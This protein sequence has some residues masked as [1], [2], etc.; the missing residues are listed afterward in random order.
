M[1]SIFSTKIMSGCSTFNK[2]VI[3][4]FGG[5][6]LS[7]E[8][9]AGEVT[10]AAAGVAND[11]S[12][13]RAT[14]AAGFGWFG[15]SGIVMNWAIFSKNSSDKIKSK[16]ETFKLA[17]KRKQKKIILKMKTEISNQVRTKGFA[18]FDVSDQIDHR[19]S[20]CVGQFIDARR[21]WQ[22]LVV[23]WIFLFHESKNEKF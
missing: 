15:S 6:S 19:S 2:I 23:F 13:R 3:L 9:G 22:I 12:T 14:G 4:L 8:T 7:D 10:P 17:V 16:L 20:W 5:V 11:G 18:F 1:S 21:E